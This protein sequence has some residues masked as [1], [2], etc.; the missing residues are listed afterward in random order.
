MVAWLHGC[1]VAWLQVRSEVNEVFDAQQILFAKRLAS[2]DLRTILIEKQNIDLLPRHQNREKVTK[3][4]GYDDAFA[5]AIFTEDGKIT[6]S[7][8][9]NGDNFLFESKGGFSHSKI[10]N[11]DDLWRIFWLPAANGR[12]TIAVGQEIDYRNDLIYSMVF[13]QMWIWFASLPFLLALI[14]WVIKRELEILS[15]LGDQLNQRTPEDNSLLATENVPREI[16]PFVDN[17][18]NFFDRTSLMLLRERRF[19]SD[20]AHELRSPLAALQ[21]QAEVAKLSSED[22][23]LRE[24][25]LDNVMQ[26][27]QRATQLIE[28][29]LTLSRLDNLQEIHWQQ[30]ITS[31]IGE[32]YFSAQERNIELIFE[33]KGSPKLQQGQPLLLALMLRNLIDNGIK[34]CRDGSII[35]VIL[36]AERII[37]EDNGGGVGED[38][39][40]KLGQRFYR[41][42]GQNEKG[43]DLGLSIVMRIAELHGYKV[44]LENVMSESQQKGLKVDILL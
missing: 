29:L 32:L 43:S 19:T 12:L 30:L 44:R 8:G 28:Q 26:G 41:P 9:R 24:K 37:V 31:L 15:L 36:T 1:M 23:I 13:G 3:K 10:R 16:I 34:Y 4:V 40:I 25:S 11:D 27:I 7:D 39:L 38:E 2:S 5:F 20:A 21:I 42:A 17:L 14:I 6:L 22:P 33:H 18:N 35:K